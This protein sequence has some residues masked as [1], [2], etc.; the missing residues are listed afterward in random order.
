MLDRHGPHQPPVPS[1]LNN[2]E[3]VAINSLLTLHNLTPSAQH[4]IPP[5]LRIPILIFDINAKGLIDTGAA[6]S[7]LSSEFLF[8]LRDKNI[9]QTAPFRLLA[10]FSPTYWDRAYRFKDE[11]LWDEIR[12]KQGNVSAFSGFMLGQCRFLIRCFWVYL[13]FF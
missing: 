4:V 12:R 2:W 9:T 1:E 5:F 13:W 3:S 8:K 6:A 11:V 10:V 7:L